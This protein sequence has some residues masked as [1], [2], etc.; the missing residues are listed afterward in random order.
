VN[1]Q[2]SVAV[3]RHGRLFKALGEP[4]RLRITALLAAT[5]ERACLCELADVLAEPDYNVSR[6]L[7]VLADVGLVAGSRSGRWIYYRFTPPAGRGGRALAIAVTES[8][9][10][11]LTADRRRFEARLAL[12]QN[13][14]CVLWKIKRLRPTFRT[15]RETGGS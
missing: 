10:E 4:V 9:G 3:L 14:Q 6:H 13:G 12:R 5:G 11:Q 7:K 15:P 2:T 1:T 8:A